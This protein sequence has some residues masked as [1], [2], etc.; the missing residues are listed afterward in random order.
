MNP[1]LILSLAAAPLFGACADEADLPPTA[2]AVGKA[3]PAAARTVQPD[4]HT[5]WVNAVVAAKLSGSLYRIGA[6]FPHAPA[7]AAVAL[8]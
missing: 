2:L 6:F 5:E 4:Q 7:A 3:H 8:P 1:C